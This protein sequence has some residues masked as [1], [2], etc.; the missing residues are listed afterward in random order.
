MQ[1]SLLV[2]RVGDYLLRPVQ[3]NVVKTVIA[4]VR[5]GKDEVI[6]SVPVKVSGNDA[7]EVGAGV[8]IDLFVCILKPVAVGF[9]YSCRTVLL[10]VPGVKDPEIVPTVALVLVADI[11]NVI[12]S[13][14]LTRS[15]MTGMTGRSVI[16]AA[17]NSDASVFRMVLTFIFL[18]LV[19]EWIY[20]LQYNYIAFQHKMQY[21]F[22]RPG[23]KRNAVFRTAFLDFIS[24]SSLFRQIVYRIDR[25]AVD[26]D[27]KVEVGS[28]RNAGNT[29]LADLLTLVYPV[30]F[31]DRGGSHVRVVGFHAILVKDLH[32][33]SVCPSVAREGNDTA[34]SRNDLVS[35]LTA[36]KINSGVEIADTDSGPAAV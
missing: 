20:V 19:S 31:L 18:L 9:R 35:D 12:A 8:K 29:D 26:P 22:C 6:L 10:S 30:A 13:A 11:G 15:A 21:L 14:A 5:D 28:R 1:L 34:V 32:K 23:K 33:N 3:G 36:C 25:I 17:K 16:T 27:L 2:P 7:E 4:V 24:L